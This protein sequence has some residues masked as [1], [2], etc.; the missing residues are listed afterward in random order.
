MA[1]ENVPTA[2]T[3]GETNPAPRQ[4]DHLLDLISAVA[5]GDA[6]R[7][8]VVAALR[9][10]GIDS[11]DVLVE[12]L[13]QVTRK[14][15]AGRRLQASLLDPQRL[16]NTTTPERAA[17]TVHQIPRLPFLLRGTIYDPADIGRFN[18]QDLHFVAIGRDDHM[19]VID[20]RSVMENWWQLSYVNSI[21][22]SN[23]I[24]L[25]ARGGELEAPLHPTNFGG[26]G[27]SGR[28]VV[29][30][31]G[32]SSSGPE[33]FGTTP[34]LSG[35]PRAVFYEDI[36]YG[37]SSIELEPNRGYADLTRVSYTFFGTGD[38]NDTI[39]SIQTSIPLW[40]VLF[41]DVDYMG[42]TFTTFGGAQNLL[43]FGWNDRASGC[44]TW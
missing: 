11:L 34:G 18:G 12:V 37:G 29:G 16:S 26:G 25:T 2:L 41:E 9:N 10:E 39:S 15:G 36:F 35:P 40:T 3:E 13:A 21:M 8:D 42:S 17:R 28:I 43:D 20:D 14:K 30:S 44:G 33:G 5:T 22:S 6:R 27:G 1:R 7:E 19:L 31:G 4:R 23:A 32:G 24:Y 38:W